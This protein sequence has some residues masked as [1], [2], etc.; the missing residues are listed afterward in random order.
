MIKRC[1]AT[2]FTLVLCMVPTG[3]LL[4][5]ARAAEQPPRDFELPQ[6]VR[7]AQ[8]RALSRKD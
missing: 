7:T 5:P 4:L 6:I 8:K 2:L 3:G 1:I